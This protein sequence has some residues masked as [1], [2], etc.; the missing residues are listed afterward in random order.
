MMQEAEGLLKKYYG[1]DSFRN[2]QA[3]AIQNV[4]EGRNSL[5][6]MPTGGGKSICYQ[7]PALMMDGITIVISPLIS[8]MKDQVDSL[9]SIGI[10]ATFINSSLSQQEV[11]ARIESARNG[12]YK[13]IYIAPERF[14]SPQFCSLIENLHISIIAIDEAHCISQWGHDFRPSYRTLSHVIQDLPMRPVIIALTATATKDV[15]HDI[16][17]LLYINEDDVF[18]TGFKRENLMLSVEKGVDKLSV[19]KD[20][21]QKY[22]ETSGIIYASTRK[23]VEKLYEYI[24]KLGFSVAKYHAGL[25][26]NERKEA[27]EAYLFDQVQVMVATNA[28]GMGI[29]KSNVRFV[30]HYQLPKNIEAYYQEAGRAGRDGEPSECTLLFSPQDVQLQK[31]LIEQNQMNSERKQQDYRKLQAMID[32]C[33]TEQCLQHHLLHY[34]GDEHAQMR[35]ENCSNC[36][37]NREKID[38]T[39][40]AQIIFSCIK[41]MKERFGVTL[42]AQVLKGSKNKRIME[43]GFHDLSTYGLLSKYT[44]KELSTTIQYLIAEGYLVLSEGQYPTLS[45]TNESRP[46]LLGEKLVYKRAA[47]IKRD[48]VVV[49]DELFNRLRAA[50]KEISTDEKIPPFVVF[51]DRTLR[52]LCEMQPLTMEELLH[53]KGIGEQKRERYG[54]KILTIIHEYVEE[55]GVSKKSEP[56]I[57]TKKETKPSYLETY[58]MYT[59]RKSLNEIAKAR[60]LSLITIQNHIVQAAEE[61]LFTTWDDVFTPE[62]EALII[63]KAMETGSD[64]LRPIKDLLPDEIDYFQ[65]KMALTKLNLQAEIV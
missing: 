23:D 56:I 12:E 16:S 27:Q 38:I 6:L 34:F 13:L 60:E 28:F 36:K 33:H 57:K 58:E 64:K 19:I 29:N 48:K 15:I 55:F 61:G 63:E 30:I 62:E 45:L 52:E 39:K 54:E 26:D 59:E 2:G 14:E 18:A 51:S 40:E 8:L 37:D 11:Y 47:M 17:S 22:K 4:L 35:C 3:S 24:K 53:V 25:N 41:R 50:R 9:L 43:L 1:Y 20:L 65:I 5:V 44:E 31:F 21:L 42:V 7:V 46:V 10:S 49:D 32:F